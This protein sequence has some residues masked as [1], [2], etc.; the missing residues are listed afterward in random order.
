MY[1]LS[2]SS[3]VILATWI[4][5][6]AVTLPIVSTSSVAADLMHNPIASSPLWSADRVQQWAVDRSPAAQVLDSERA[7]AGTTIDRDDPKQC[8]QAHLK[9]QVLADFAR[10][11]RNRA[12]ADALEVYCR[13]VG[14]ARQRQFLVE[15]TAVIDRLIAMADEAD[16]LDIG[17]EDP[18]DLR[19]NRLGVEDKILQL[20]SGVAKLRIQLAQLTGQSIDSASQ[21]ILI[22]PMLIDST[23]P[24][25]ED[26]VAVALSR[27]ADLRALQTLSQRLDANTLPAA[28]DLLAA[29]NP[30]LGMVTKFATRMAL[31]CLSGPDLSNNDLRLRRQQCY[32]LAEARSEQIEFE[33]RRGLVDLSSARG[34]GELAGLRSHL[35]SQSIEQRS[36]AIELDRAPPGSDL[37]VTLEM[38]TAQG[39]QT[40]N[41]ID[42]AVAWIRLLEAQG[43][44]SDPR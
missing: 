15:A 14:L 31:P 24:L 10:H 44:A 4:V 3:T 2:S 12:A 13:I 6:I 30:G 9:Q 40:Q 33:V 16:L 23:V 26:A 8:A 32:Q 34:R 5:L 7:A 1:A 20:D 35:A 29:Q 41:Q 38:L 22:T 25:A 28:R 11:E 18:N 42:E 39:D 17:K 21:A 37:L 27:R 43:I 19:R 36:T